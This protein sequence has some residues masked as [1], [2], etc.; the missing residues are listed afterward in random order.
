LRLASLYYSALKVAGLTAIARRLSSG[1]VI[2]CYHNI[3]AGTEA[4]P[5]DSLGL[6]M[7]LAT[8]SRQMRWLARTYQI[9]PLAELVSSVSNGGSLRG[10]AAVTFDDGYASVFENAWPVLRDLGIPATVFV[11]AEVP[12]RDEHFWWDDPDVLRAYSP[13]RRED[14]LAT[15]RG[16]GA[17][18]R[19]SLAPA[20]RPP[21]RQPPLRPPPWCKPATWTTITDAA[22]S[23]LQLGV[24]SATHRS[25][26]VLDELELQHE[27]V[28]SREIIR[29]RTG[30]TPEFFAYPYGLWNDRV[31]DAVRT[32]GYRAAFTLESGRRATTTDRWTLPRVSVPARIEDAAFHAWTAGLNPRRGR[33]A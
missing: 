14:W 30:V 1:G 8:F 10:V 32:A 11:V 27:V 4:D 5:S 28:E 6:H 24:H 16:D 13:A 20:R 12:G 2:L 17:A 18:I 15:F 3:I 21:S 25:L 29:S 26:P 31:R 23:G 7:P 22:R 33:G 19:D 9:V